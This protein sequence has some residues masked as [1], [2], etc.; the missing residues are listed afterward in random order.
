MSSQTASRPT[1][2]TTPPFDYTRDELC[3]YLPSGWELLDDREPVWNAKKKQLT[4]RVIDGVDFDWPVVIAARAVDAHG[5]L[6]ALERAMD[7]TFR[8]RLGKPTR[9]LGI[10]RRR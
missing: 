8:A 3:S 4:V 1:S 5:R 6:G 2:S 9:G 7:D 10:G